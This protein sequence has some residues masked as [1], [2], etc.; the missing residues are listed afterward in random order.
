MG[1][2]EKALTRSRR[3][4]RCFEALREMGQLEPWLKEV[5][6]LIGVKQ[7][8][9]CH[10]EGDA[11]THDAEFN[12]RGGPE[13]Q[14]GRKTRQGLMLAALLHD[15]GKAVAMQEKDGVI[16]AYGHETA[17]VPLAEEFCGG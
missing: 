7:R 9:D 1:E 6:A 12:S 2:T 11:W 5:A 4:S 13:L 17:G 3:P 14:D 15:V 8:A 10:P 16:H